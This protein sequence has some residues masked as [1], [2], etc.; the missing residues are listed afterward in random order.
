[1][2]KLLFS[3]V[4]IIYFLTGYS[5]ELEQGYNYTDD[6]IDELLAEESFADILAS[7]ANFQF[8]YFSCNYNTNTY[9][10]GR[11]IDVDQFNISPQIAYM[12]SKGF[13]ASIS[14]IIYGEFEPHWDVTIAS[15][16]YGKSFGKNKI[17]RYFGSLSGY[18][19]ADN[20]V[21]GLYNASANAGINVQNKKRT[22]GTQIS[23]TY[24]FGGEATYQIVSTTFANLKLLKNKNH[25]LKLR[26]QISIITGTQLVD[27]EGVPLQKDVLTKVSESIDETATTAAEDVNLTSNVFQLIYSQL[28]IP[29]QYNYK[30]FDFEIG[31]NINFPSELENETDLKNTSFFNFGIAYMLDL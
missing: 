5:Q 2:K 8:L 1:M 9:F 3:S 24:Y 29:L 4:F 20:D 13:Y 16:G 25:S 23:G 26:P 7:Y 27:I 11:E 12:H 10:S 31:F 6:I 19:Y 14:G 18:L 21:E 17:F 15:A 28:N 30:S 22:I